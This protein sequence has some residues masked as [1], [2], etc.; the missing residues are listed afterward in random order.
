MYASRTLI[1]C[2]QER[3][4]KGFWASIREV[5]DEQSLANK[6]LSVESAL[7]MRVPVQIATKSIDS[8]FSLSSASPVYV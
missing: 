5:H 8:C 6:T 2:M 4:N 3:L 1:A 7:K